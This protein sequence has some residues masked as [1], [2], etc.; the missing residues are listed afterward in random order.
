MT[1]QTILA[2]SDF[3]LEGAESVELSHNGAKPADV[4][5]TGDGIHVNRRIEPNSPVT[6][7]LH[8]NP[9]T[10]TNKSKFTVTVRW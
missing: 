2:G 4:E 6:E 8:G 10:I 1:T 5:I 3:V 7:V 9:V